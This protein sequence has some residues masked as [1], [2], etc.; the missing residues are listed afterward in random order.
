M[1][2]SKQT[3]VGPR[4]SVPRKE[5]MAFAELQNHPGRRLWHVNTYLHF[6]PI[7]L[8]FFCLL[9]INHCCSVFQVFSILTIF[10]SWIWWWEF[11]ITSHVQPAWCDSWQMP[12]IYKKTTEIPFTFEFHF[13]VSESSEFCLSLVLAANKMVA[14]WWCF[15][16]SMPSHS[17]GCHATLKHPTCRPSIWHERKA[18]LLRLLRHCTTDSA[19]SPSWRYTCFHSYIIASMLISSHVHG[20]LYSI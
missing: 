7:K 6:L 18:D 19:A 10:R 13:Q 20:I 5:K 11:I 12:E 2:C 3:N 4:P 17:D 1:G 15:P 14:A 16:S 9:R 8:H